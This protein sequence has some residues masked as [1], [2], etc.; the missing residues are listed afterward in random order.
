MQGIVRDRRGNWQ[1]RF[2][3]LI[4]HA[5]A[6][7]M[8]RFEKNLGRET[9]ETALSSNKKYACDCVSGRG[10]SDWEHSRLRLSHP[11]A[12]SNHPLL[13]SNP[14]TL[15]PLPWSSKAPRPHTP[16]TSSTV[17]RQRQRPCAL[18]TS[19]KRG[20]AGRSF[21]TRHL[22][23]YFS[24]LALTL[25]SVSHFHLPRRPLPASVSFFQI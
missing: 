8:N 10:L 14:L 7:I 4:R 9:A 23:L 3:E 13:Y 11:T 1:R 15:P 17:R 20:T 16:D 19:A 18:G 5:V 2:S 21:G 24:L 25:D 6:G 12:S 22:E